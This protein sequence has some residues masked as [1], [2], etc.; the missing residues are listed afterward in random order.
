M[1]A[2]G[3]AAARASLLQTIKRTA[4]AVDAAAVLAG[5]GQKAHLLAFARLITE[6]GQDFRAGAL[7]DAARMRSLELAFRS[8]APARIPWLDDAVSPS[9]PSVQG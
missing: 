5:P 9:Q 2:A 1:L 4:R 6:V 7:P 8:S 3:D